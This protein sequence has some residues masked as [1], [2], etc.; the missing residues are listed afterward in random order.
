MSALKDFFGFVGFI[1]CGVTGLF[2]I[3]AMCRSVKTLISALIWKYRYK[4]R[5]DRPPL[6][7]CYCRDC[8]HNKDGCSCKRNHGDDWFCG[9]AEPLSA[10]EV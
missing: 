6:A 4:H 1:A 10:E 8:W 2:L 7:K 3:E 9:D 5:F